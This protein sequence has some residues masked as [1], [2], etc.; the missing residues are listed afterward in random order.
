MLGSFVALAVLSV[1]NKRPSL[2]VIVAWIDY[3]TVM[4]LFGMMIIVGILS[5]T[6]I[7][8]WAAVKAYKI[9][10]GEVWRLMTVLCL[11]S[12]VVS[13]FLDNVTTILLLTPVT[14]RM[15][16]VIGLDPRPILLAEVVFSNIGGTATA[17]GDPPN[18][19]IVSSNWSEV[20]GEKDIAFTEFTGHMFV[21]IIL[22]TGWPKEW[23]GA[24]PRLLNNWTPSPLSHLLSA[25]ALHVPQRGVQEPRLARG[26]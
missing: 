22:V 10:R 9:S 19:I 1:L 14:I 12:A 11:F 2:E 15:C 26:G 17:V 24:I 23:E 21:G 16:N 6:G 3:E 25:A 8:E 5:E 20:D 18:V 13:A 4:L 7:F